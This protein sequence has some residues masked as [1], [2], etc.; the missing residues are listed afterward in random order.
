M[1]TKTTAT[2]LT[3]PLLAMMVF[4]G[5][6][7]CARGVGKVVNPGVSIAAVKSKAPASVASY[8]ARSRGAY[9]IAT[10]QGEGEA[11][12]I[13]FCAEPPPD[14]AAN[15][16]AKSSTMV[17]V[18]LALTYEMIQAGLEAGVATNSSASS[19]IADAATRT[20]LI[21]VTRDVLY[22]ICEMHANSVLTSDEAQELFTDMIRTIRS[23]GQRDNVG[24]LVD[25][26]RLVITSEAPDQALVVQ[27]VGLIKSLALVDVALA[28]SASELGEQRIIN[29]LLDD[30]SVTKAELEAAK[31][32]L[33]REIKTLEQEQSELE[34]QQA[35]LEQGR[36]GSRN[37]AAKAAVADKLEFVNEQ[38]QRL[39]TLEQG[40]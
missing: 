27:L 7:G 12:L 5:T 36:E 14:V 19:T 40:L 15:I 32:A 1:A 23:L 38:L 21:L 3:L 35:E 11:P 4:S 33:N 37:S 31:L 2:R 16:D 34:S 24:K 28:G 39:K 17:D 6:T 25:A 22:R 30:G 20:E 26:L 29:Q 8:D 13:R 9:L 18:Q 10:P